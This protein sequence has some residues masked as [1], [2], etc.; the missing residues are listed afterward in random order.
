MIFK[1]ADKKNQ[2]EVVELKEHEKLFAI[3]EVNFGYNDV[4]SFRS[5]I[6]H[7]KLGYYARPREDFRMSDALKLV[8]KYEGGL[9]IE[10]MS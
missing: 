5:V 1:S 4:E 10:D 8:D 6:N 9:L 2:I 3:V 7:N